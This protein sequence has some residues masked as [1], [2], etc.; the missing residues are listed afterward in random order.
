MCLIKL[1]YNDKKNLYKVENSINCN[2]DK[3]YNTLN[4]YSINSSP[5]LKSIKVKNK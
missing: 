2:F 3:V 1:N 5:F 4:T